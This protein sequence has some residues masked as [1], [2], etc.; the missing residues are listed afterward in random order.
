MRRQVIQIVLVI[1]LFGGAMS[2]AIACV[3]RQSDTHSCCRLLS[4]NQPSIARLAAKTNHKSSPVPPCCMVSVPVAPEPAT[5]NNRERQAN[6]SSQI[7]DDQNHLSDFVA[8]RTFKPSPLS[9][10]AGYSPPPFILHHAL[11]I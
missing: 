3:S 11:L 10:P 1:S 9:E 7:I 6:P 2:Q 8:Q 5:V 4:T